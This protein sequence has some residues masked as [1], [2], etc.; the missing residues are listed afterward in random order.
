MAVNGSLHRVFACSAGGPGFD[1]RLRRLVASVLPMFYAE[2]VGGP[3]QAPTLAKS[4]IRNRK[5]FCDF[6]N[7]SMHS[8]SSIIY[9]IRGI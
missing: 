1:S 9:Q 7:N 4:Q 5:F 6:R 8:T 3:G 2:D